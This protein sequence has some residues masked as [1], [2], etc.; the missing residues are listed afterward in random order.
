MLR[1]W[2][3]LFDALIRLRLGLCRLAAQLRHLFGLSRNGLR[4]GRPLDLVRLDR[5]LTLGCGRRLT[6]GGRF[7]LL[8]LLLELF[9]LRLGR[10]GLDRSQEVLLRVWLR[11]ELHRI[12]HRLD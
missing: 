2:L 7:L 1:G 9:H 4:W 6:L 3:G 11:F 5:D 12:V 8:L 10:F